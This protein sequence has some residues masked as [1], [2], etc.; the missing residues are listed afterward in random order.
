MI[1]GNPL[2]DVSILTRRE[3]N[4]GLIMNVGVMY[5]NAI[6][7]ASRAIALWVGVDWVF[8]VCLDRWTFPWA[9]PPAE[10]GQDGRIDH[11]VFLACG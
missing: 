8:R 3:K 5:N 6:G 7:P 9:R 1:D 2:S 10:G 4:L 11:R